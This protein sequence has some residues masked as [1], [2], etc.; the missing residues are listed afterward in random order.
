MKLPSLLKVLL[1]LL[2]TIINNFPICDFGHSS[3]T[4]K[5]KRKENHHLTLKHVGH[6]P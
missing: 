2:G 6:W 1:A 5:E 3:V 4:E